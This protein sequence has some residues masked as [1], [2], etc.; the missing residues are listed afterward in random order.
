MLTRRRLVAS[1]F[2]VLATPAALARAAAPPVFYRNPGC[3]CCLAWTE[4]MAAAG[5][6]VT[7]DDKEDLAGFSASLGIPAGLE[8][9][10]VGEIGG[11]VVSGHVP[12][13]DIKRLL[14]EKPTAR[15]LLVPGMPVGSPGMEMGEQK[16]R[17]DVLLLAKDGT[18][19]VFAS[20]G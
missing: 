11:Y 9:C 6:P 2:A 13:E 5:L 15:G 8:G 10:H 1:L 17:Y 16:D 12:P 4:R 19:T 14:S 7:M 18:T 20:H 3:G